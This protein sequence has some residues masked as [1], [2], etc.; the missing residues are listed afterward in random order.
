MVGIL[1]AQRF[2]SAS[3]VQNCLDSTEQSCQ[4]VGDCFLL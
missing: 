1:L 2:K 3:G 4:S